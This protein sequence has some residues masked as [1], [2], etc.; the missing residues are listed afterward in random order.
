CL[1]RAKELFQLKDT[2]ENY[3]IV[4][5]GLSEIYSILGLNIAAKQYALAG[6]WAC[7][8]FGD[9]TALNR[10]SDS[11][12]YVFRADYNQGAWMSALDDFRQYIKVRIEFKSDPINIE[13]DA[14]YIKYLIV[15]A[16]SIE[17][18][19]LYHTESR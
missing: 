6:V 15:Y 7:F 2:K 11:Y 18:W 19:P 5:L 17:L 10:I 12:A 14:V 1:H 9:A 13:A 16:V 8:H 3:I 4:M